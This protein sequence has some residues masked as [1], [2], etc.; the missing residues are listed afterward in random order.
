MTKSHPSL[1]FVSLFLFLILKEG[2]ASE[3]RVGAVE[4]S[5]RGFVDKDGVIRGSSVEITNLVVTAA[6]YTP[7]NKVLPYPRLLR[8]LELGT[9]DAA[10]LVPNEN[11]TK[12]ATPLAYLQ[13]V[14][15]ILLTKPEDQ[16]ASLDAVSGMKIGHLRRSRIS[17]KLLSSIEVE[18]VQG[19]SYSHMLKLLLK[20][21][22]DGLVG[23]RYNIEFA[24]QELELNPDRLSQPLTLKRLELH[25]VYSKKT[26]EPEK[27]DALTSA[28]NSL[29]IEEQVRKVIEKYKAL[30]TN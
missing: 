17:E 12:I 15:F 11:V 16:V 22:L 24:I 14:E 18:A 26:A 8:E 2:W 28:A 6:G 30:P 1:L 3:I 21:R 9:L 25:L 20:G 23:T 29:V 10:L 4:V 13:D 27:I 19:D 5:Q 7:V